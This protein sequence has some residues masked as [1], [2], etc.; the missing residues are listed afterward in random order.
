MSEYQ[1]FEWLAVDRPLNPK[2]TEEVHGLS[3]HMDVATSTQAIVTYQWGDFKHDPEQVLL[4]YFDAFFYYAN[5]GTRRLMFRFPIKSIDVEQILAYCHEDAV[6]L[7]EYG[8][9]C[10]LEI[11]LND[12]GGYYEWFPNFDEDEEGGSLGQYLP[13][14]EQ[15]MEGDYRALYLAWLNAAA[16]FTSSASSGNGATGR[17]AK[18]GAYGRDEDYDSEDEEESDEDDFESSWEDSEPPVPPGLNQ[19]DDALK[20]LVHFLQLDSS[21]IQ[22]A[23][24]ASGA[25]KPSAE[26]SLERALP[27]L[28]RAECEA[29]LL[30]VLNNEWA[31]RGELR[32]RLLELSGHKQASPAPGTR[33]PEEIVALARGIDLAAKEKARAEAERKRIADLQA[34]SK[35][36]KETWVSV[37]QLIEEK[38]ASSYA[39]AVSLLVQLRDL[40]DFEDSFE[41]YQE[42]LDDLVGH[43]TKR[44]ALLDRLRSAG[45]ID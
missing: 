26:T 39:E 22:A 19:L 21:L 13:L 11:S 16:P 20:A 1:Y 12:E 27:K 40:A 36:Q 28:T 38:K 4:K 5:W 43:Y 8:N 34:L 10:V 33:R 18:A 32:R 42:R 3:S 23:A 17:A 31:V 15:I 14:R 37:T 7:R 44:P 30:R 35:R 29:Y 41:D 24:Q 6:T 25:M 45:L 2:E 9:V